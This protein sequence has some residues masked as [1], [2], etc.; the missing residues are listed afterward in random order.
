[1]EKESTPPNSP[2]PMNPLPLKRRESEDPQPKPRRG[3]KPRKSQIP[4]PP[5][6]H[7]MSNSS[8]MRKR[9][10]INI[11]ELNTEWEKDTENIGDCGNIGN[12]YTANS[13]SNLTNSNPQYHKTGEMGVLTTNKSLALTIYEQRLAYGQQVANGLCSE[14]VAYIPSNTKSENIPNL[15]E[16]SKDSNNSNYIPGNIYT[17]ISESEGEAK[18]KKCPK[19][20]G[21]IGTNINS[22]GTNINSTGTTGTTGTNINTIGN[23]ENNINNT[24]TTGT[25]GTIS[26]GVCMH[27]K[28]SLGELIKGNIRLENAQLRMG[29]VRVHIREEIRKIDQSIL[30]KHQ[31]LARVLGSIAKLQGTAT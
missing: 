2:N 31:Q 3:R 22:T 6:I 23:I 17:Y 15:R 29:K 1:M 4:Y 26:D 7:S 8:R 16:I 24:G 14:K 13:N 10:K 30:D 25:T 9:T 28:R 18:C 11:D 21:N 19:C 20:Q 5:N 27:C 12:I